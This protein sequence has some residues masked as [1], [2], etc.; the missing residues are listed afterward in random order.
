MKK[1]QVITGAISGASLCA[2]AKSIGLQ[3]VVNLR[4]LNGDEAHCSL[5]PFSGGYA[6][7]IDSMHG[8]RPMSALLRGNP[9][10]YIPHSQ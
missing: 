6:R 9:E 1:L 4:R 3:D 5:V 8:I 7:L 2:I 10:L